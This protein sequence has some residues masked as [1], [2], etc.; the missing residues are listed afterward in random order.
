MKLEDFKNGIGNIK[1]DPYMETRLAQKVYEAAPKKRSKKKLLIAAISGILSLALIVT[2]LGFGGFLQ[3]FIPNDPNI[4]NTEYLPTGGEGNIEYER[5]YDDRI[6]GLSGKLIDYIIETSEKDYNSWQ[7]K[8]FEST[9][10]TGISSPDYVPMLLAAIEEFN[11][12]KEAFEKINNEYI[13]MYKNN[14]WEY[15]IP[16]VCYTQDE[17]DAIYSIDPATI[18]KTFA[19]EYAIIVGDRAC[20]PEWYLNAT[21]K[22]LKQYG[23]STSDVESKTELLLKDGIIKTQE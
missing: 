14:D 21:Q 8:W 6:Y 13:E 1:P 22:E 19:S 23:V 9:Q 11:I 2:A 18:T 10:I 17:I 7:E 20:S 5:A 15:M 16:Q 12:S 3:D 4:D